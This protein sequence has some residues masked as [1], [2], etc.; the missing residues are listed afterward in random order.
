MSESRDGCVAWGARQG[1]DR[2]IALRRG[3]AAGGWVVVDACGCVFEW[4]NHARG[5]GVNVRVTEGGWVE[6]VRPIERGGELV[7]DYGDAFVI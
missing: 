3:E 2:L 7:W 1:R 4:S 5:A 6:A